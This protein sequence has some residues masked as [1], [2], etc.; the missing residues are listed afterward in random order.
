M[1]LTQKNL[2]EILCEESLSEFIGVYDYAHD[3]NDN[4]IFYCQNGYRGFA[5]IIEPSAYANLKDHKTLVS[6]F[7]LELPVGSVI[8]IINMPSR[9]LYPIFEFYSNARNSYDKVREP[10]RLKMQ[11]SRRIDWLK[12][13]IDKG[14]INNSFEFYPKNWISLAVVM[15]PEKGKKKKY[16]TDSEILSYQNKALSKLHYFSPKVASPQ[17]IIRFLSEVLEPHK[18]EWLSGWD[19]ETPINKQVTSSSTTYIDND[20]GTFTVFDKRDKENKYHYSVLT[21]KKFPDMLNVAVTQNLFL[22]NFEDKSD[23]PYMKNPFFTCVSIVI[24]DKQKERNSL[25]VKSKNNQYQASMLKDGLRFFPK[26]MEIEKE[27]QVLDYL[28]TNRNETIYRMQFSIVVMSDSKSKLENQVSLIESNFG[29]KNWELQVECDMAI[30]VFLYSLPF[31]FDIRYKEMSDRFKTTLRSNNAAATPLLNDSKGSYG[32][33]PL[34]I[35]FGQTGQVQFFDNFNTIGNANV[36]VAAGS[37]SGK[38]F[39]MLEY[40]KSSLE[41]GRMVRIIEAGRSFEG[42]SQEYGGKYLSFKDED[43]VCLNF[44]TDA[45]TINEGKE[46]HPEEVTTII[47]LIGLMIGRQLI[48]S[49]DDD[50]DA[51]STSDNTIISS[52]IEQAV[53]NAYKSQLRQ[54]GLADV[55]NQLVTIFKTIEKNENFTDDRLRDVITALSPYSEESGVYYSYFN[56]PRNIYFSDNP[57]VVF[58]LNDLKNKDEKLMFVVLMALIKIVANEFYGEEFEDILKALIC[59]EAWM[60]LDNQFIASFLIRVWRTIAKHKGCGISISQDIN[61]YF[62]N[63]DMEA[64]Y[65]N[66]TYKIFLRQSPEQLDRLSAENKLSNDKFFLD[67]LKG[68]KSQAGYF[69]E[70][71]VKVEESYFLSRIIYDKFSFYLYSTPDKVPYFS[72]IRKKFD[73]QK[74]ETAFLFAYI[75]ENPEKSF[76]EAYE[77]LLYEKGIKVRENKNDSDVKIIPEN[78]MP[79][80]EIKEVSEVEIGIKEDDI[81]DLSMSDEIGVLSK[82][83]RVIVNIFKK[84]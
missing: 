36:V 18:K 31:N 64:I 69:S 57:L 75:D 10:E 2:E 44:F 19:R 15:I 28:I 5:Y 76:E 32:R 9:N 78:E 70:M 72:E 81:I 39:Y 38:T 47:P 53:K 73:L 13:S 50:F 84:N 6:Y 25:Q 82:I 48:S 40:A 33:H 83:K 20:D 54:T 42:L 68:L 14:L 56:G 3:E 67:K 80:I 1:S 58:E 24:E 35:Q 52:Y 7:D 79:Q 26:L 45:K 61:L 22:E 27:A 34:M 66:S 43:N 59:D 21:T 74:N 60:L 55:R 4:G 29:K 23:E 12:K 41:L 16:I 11:N 37:R 30:P 17:D 62:K 46:L 77:E 51:Q 49:N 63:K 8:Q 71:L 65:D